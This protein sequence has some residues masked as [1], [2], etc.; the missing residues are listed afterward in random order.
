MGGGEVIAWPSLEEARAW[1][2]DRKREIGPE[3]PLLLDRRS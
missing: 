3:D 1:H 2:A